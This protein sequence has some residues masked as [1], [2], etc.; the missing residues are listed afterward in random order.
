M[1]A[2]LSP[3]P[4]PIDPDRLNGWKEI[5]VHLGRGVRT[6]QRWEKEYGLP[7]RRLGH[8]DGEIIVASRRELDE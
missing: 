1:A 4:P 7:V 5:A 2:P 3:A 6:A 8:K